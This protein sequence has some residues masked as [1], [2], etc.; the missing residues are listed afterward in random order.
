V[1]QPAITLLH[2][3]AEGPTPAGWESTSDRGYGS[4]DLLKALVP[5]VFSADALN[6][7]DQ[8]TPRSDWNAKS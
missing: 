7:S 1:T 4:S 6:Q 3:A 2:Q 8:R 5:L